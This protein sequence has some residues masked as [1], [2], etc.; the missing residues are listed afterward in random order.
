MLLMTSLSKD[1]LPIAT[2][3]PATAKSQAPE[4]HLDLLSAT[5]ACGGPTSVAEEALCLLLGGGWDHCP[6][7]VVNEGN[8]DDQEEQ[9]LCLPDQKEPAEGL[10]VWAQSMKNTLG[11]THARFWGATGILCSSD[12]WWAA[13]IA[14]SNPEE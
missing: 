7:Q 8:Q 6:H 1:H 4:M 14:L 9:Y 12:A 11:E 5:P 2:S 10:A 13:E 3:P